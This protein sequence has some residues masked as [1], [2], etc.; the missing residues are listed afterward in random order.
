MVHNVFFIVIALCASV[1]KL[2]FLQCAGDL[3]QG[4]RDTYELE[5][6]VTEERH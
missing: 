3:G 5:L 6:D 4:V 2:C 1:V